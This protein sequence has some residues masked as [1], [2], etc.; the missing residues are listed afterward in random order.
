MMDK[1]TKEFKLFNITSGELYTLNSG[2]DEE[3]NTIVIAL[4]RGKY[5]EQTIKT[6]DEFIEMCQDYLRLDDT[7]SE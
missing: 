5:D 4:L 7:Q 1:P 2:L 6:D 3:L